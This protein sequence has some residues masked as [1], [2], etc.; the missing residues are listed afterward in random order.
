MYN[1]KS[2]ENP[3]LSKCRSG[4]LKERAW[5]HIS[6]RGEGGGGGVGGVTKKYRISVLKKIPLLVF[7]YRMFPELSITGEVVVGVSWLAFS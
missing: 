3:G 5:T 4:T 7:F 1:S 6:G 2:F